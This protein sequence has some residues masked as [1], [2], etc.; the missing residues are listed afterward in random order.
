MLLVTHLDL[1]LLSIFDALIEQRSVTRVAERLGITQSAVSHALGRLRRSLDDP[2]FVRGPNGFQPTPRAEEIAPSIRDGLATLRGALSPGVFDPQTSQRRFTIAASAYFCSL[3]IPS[4]I[5]E[6]RSAAPFISL[7]I[8]P[9]SDRIGAWLDRGVIDLALG[10]SIAVPPRYIVEPLWTETM[11]WIA[12]AS[13]PICQ[14]TIGADRIDAQPRVMI[15]VDRPFEMPSPSASE[16]PQVP[17]LHTGSLVRDTLP[18]PGESITVYDS[19]TAVALVA[20]TDLV[21][22]IPRRVAQREMAHT[23]IV[24][25]DTNTDEMS[26]EVS[27]QWHQNQRADKGLIWLR[28][29][30]LALTCRN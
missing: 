9:S 18:H 24:I 30:L 12:A 26:F 14:G 28:E 25:L 21:A 16:A 29:T 1:N 7:R 17:W 20:R 27:M 10:S 23:P 13:N 19:Q 6:T 22:S 5:E 4:L 11:V 2:L 15:S 8:L 3:L